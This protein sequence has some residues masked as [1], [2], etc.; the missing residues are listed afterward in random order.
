MGEHVDGLGGTEFVVS[1]PLFRLFERIIGDLKVRDVLEHA[2]GIIQ[3]TLDC[4]R[5]TVYQ[6]Q[7]DTQELVSGAI[8]GNVNQIIR[9]PIR[10]DSLAGYCAV[11]RR[12]FAVPD[13]YGDLSVV[14]PAL[15][16]DRSW[17]ARNGFRTRDVICVPALFRGEIMGVIQAINKRDGPFE[18]RDIAPMRSLATL[19][20]YTLYN[21]QLY[22]DLETLKGLKRE[23]AK[24]MRVLVH[25]LKSPATG[26]K[27]LV[28]AHRFVHGD[29]A[30]SAEVLGRVDARM[31]QMLGIIEDILHLSQIQKGE[32]LG[33][34]AVFDVAARTAE[35]AGG[36]AD[37]AR[38]KGL[39]LTLDISGDPIHI[40]FDRKGWDMVVSNLV[41]NAVK[42]TPEGAVSVSVSRLVAPDGGIP[43]V[44]LEVR[45]TGL[46]IPEDDIPR[47]FTEFFRA[48][49]VRAGDIK[50]TGVG[51]AGIR[52]LVERFNGRISFE[53]RVGE[54]S[55][56]TVSVPDADVPAAAA[57]SRGGLPSA[58][59]SDSFPW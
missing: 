17:D 8:I 54:G 23:K 30:V 22:E 35:V 44:L 28:S 5:V 14:D 27:S 26:A 6:V 7:R 32:P 47:L 55:T 56:F 41:S 33:E 42:Y 29:D 46:G 25:E 3:E 24:F 59:D 16:F 9:V 38:E 43:K 10:E 31:D 39:C 20:G 49:N 37:Q 18:A 53:S 52:D 13:A 58:P 4:E 45:D 57:D 34:V 15:R 2:S 19:V 21:A 40:R 51:L 36:Y 12:C 11:S 1:D 50:G 48:S